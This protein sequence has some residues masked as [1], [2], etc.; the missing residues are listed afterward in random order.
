MAVK[1]E[2]NELVTRAARARALCQ[3]CGQEKATHKVP[4]GKGPYRLGPKC[5]R[6]LEDIARAAGKVVEARL[7]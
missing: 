1:P 3:L 7:L 4:S 2:P 6:I 5:L